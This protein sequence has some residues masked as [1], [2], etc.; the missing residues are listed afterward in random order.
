MKYLTFLD[1]SDIGGR[2]VEREAKLD[3][4]DKEIAFLQE[5]YNESVRSV[6]LL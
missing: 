6:S 2:R 3:A 4:K 1:Y 5:R